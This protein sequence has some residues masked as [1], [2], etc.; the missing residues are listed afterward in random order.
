MNMEKWY[1]IEGKD[2][3]VVVA[4]R[5]RLSRN[6]DGRKF[7]CTLSKEEAD[8][9]LRISLGKYNNKEEIG[10]FCETLKKLVCELRSIGGFKL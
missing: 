9:S 3:D 1:R 7:P 5:V 6:I 4:S 2:Q 8:S 10:I